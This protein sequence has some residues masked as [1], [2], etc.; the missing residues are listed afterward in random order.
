MPTYAG[1]RVV[2]VPAAACASPAAPPSQMPLNNCGACLDFDSGENN[3]PAT[4][5]TLHSEYYTADA[6]LA[7]ET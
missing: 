5:N 3:M 6:I 1:V 4:L 7:A 2:G